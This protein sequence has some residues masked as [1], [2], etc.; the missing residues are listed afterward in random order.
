MEAW[1]KNRDSQVDKQLNTEND[2]RR[3]SRNGKTEKARSKK[4]D[5]RKLEVWKN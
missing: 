2:T 3:D 4:E 1:E 5:R